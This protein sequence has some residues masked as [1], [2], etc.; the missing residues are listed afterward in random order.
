MQGRSPK[1][2]GEEVRASNEFINDYLYVKICLIPIISITIHIPK[3]N[4]KQK[5]PAQT[6]INKTHTKKSMPNLPPPPSNNPSKLHTLR[7][8]KGRN[9]LIECHEHPNYH[10]DGELDDQ[11]DHYRIVLLLVPQTDLLEGVD[12]EADEDCKDCV[13]EEF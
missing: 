13:G 12:E 3:N 5:Y 2:I 1:D 8:H 6:Y 10:D 9:H 4:H 7:S 11:L